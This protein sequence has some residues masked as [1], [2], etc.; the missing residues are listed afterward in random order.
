M[1]QRKRERMY[2]VHQSLPQATY[3]MLLSREPGRHEQANSKRKDLLLYGKHKSLAG[4]YLIQ[5]TLLPLCLLL[6]IS[7]LLSMVAKGKSYR[8]PQHFPALTVFTMSQAQH[9]WEQFVVVLKL[10]RVPVEQEHVGMGFGT[11]VPY[12]LLDPR[13]FG[14][15]SGCRAQQCTGAYSSQ[16]TAGC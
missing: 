11:A 2:F 7:V 15:V 4:K 14:G 1:A 12:Y 10:C 9:K 6:S 13:V 8:V 5:E 16:L 3:L